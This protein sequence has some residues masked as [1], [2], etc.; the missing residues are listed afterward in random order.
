MDI[1]DEWF[2]TN[3]RP[4]LLRSEH[5]SLIPS[6]WIEPAHS[7]ERCLAYIVTAGEEIA[8]ALLT[9]PVEAQISLKLMAGLKEIS[10]DG[11]RYE[12]LFDQLTHQLPLLSGSFI[13]AHLPDKAQ[14]VTIDV[15]HLSNQT[16]Q[17]LLRCSAGP[18]GYS[19]ADWLAVVGFAI[20]RHDRIA[21][22]HSRSNTQ[23][24][25]ANEIAHFN[26]VYDHNI[27]QTR[28]KPVGCGIASANKNS[29]S[30]VIALSLEESQ[31]TYIAQ[32]NN[33]IA[34]GRGLVAAIKPEP[35]ED[36]YHYSSR[37]LGA[38]I[39]KPPPN[40]G[41]RASERTGE[42]A[43]LSICCGEAGIEASLLGGVI[44][45]LNLV[46]LDINESLLAKAAARF[47]NAASC[48][49]IRGDVN[50]LPLLS[51]S[52]DIIIISSALHH[53]VELE[54]FAEF[55]RLMLKP[56]GDF[57]VIG[58]NIGRTGSR[59]TPDAYQRA[60]EIFRNLPRQFRKNRSTEK[61]DS[62]LPNTD[63]SSA[64]FEGIRSNELVTILRNFFS[65]VSEYS[66][67]CFLWRLLDLA[68]V[69]NYDLQDS[70]NL[71][72]VRELCISEWVYWCEGGAATELH[73]IYKHKC[74]LIR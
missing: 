68:Y 37:L 70:E 60:N 25:I 27:Y 20:G 73:G 1:A 7:K 48:T 49:T 40:F 63:C 43:V 15:S 65:P 3:E 69:D 42:I 21:L 74:N 66:R 8:S 4:V 26:N 13:N 24:R 44:S 53:V 30:P 16:G 19:E 64:C 61:I 39:A 6:R 59:L 10:R 62:E 33:L 34:Q 5:P 58:E 11:L 35:R 55:V 46:L 36:A 51:Q 14:T 32:H 18:E 50:N 12:L 47:T 38:L 72:A 29:T 52:F 22:L 28:S 57:W 67:N 31:Q 23:W 56:D 9:V 71:A 54:N 41:R 2:I 45:R 17:F